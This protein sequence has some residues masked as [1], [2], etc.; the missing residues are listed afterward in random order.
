MNLSIRLRLTLL[1]F[2]FFALAG[3]L[4]GLASWL[5]LERSLTALMLH[6]LDERIDDLQSFLASRPPG[7]GLEAMRAELLREYRLKDEGKWLQITDGRGEWLYFS[8][9]G[10]VADLLS[11]LPPAPGSLTPFVPV[12]GHSLRSLTRELN[13]AGQTY[14]VSMAI[15]A[16]LSAVIL[17]R[18]GRDLWLLVPLVI[19]LA[20][21]VGHFL[22]RKALDPVQSIVTEVR[23]INERNLSTR[24]SVSRANDELSLLS[25]TLNQMLERIDSA[26]RSVRVLT[27]NAS[28]ELRT[29]LTLIR[30]RLEIALCFPRKIDYYQSVLEEVLAESV[31]MSALVENLLTMARY[32]AG[33]AQTELLPV[34][35][36]GLLSKAAREWIATAERLSLDLQFDGGQEPL[37]VLADPDLIE[38][39]VRIL[40]DN[41]CRYTPPGG[42]VRLEGKVCDDRVVVTVQDSGIGIAEQDLPRIFERFYRAQQPRHHERR[43][44]GLGLA[45]ARWIAEQHKASI[46]VDSTPGSGSRFEFTFPQFRSD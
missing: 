4:L 20:A 10:R 7:T 44:S 22:S 16:D 34:D 14:H 46:T 12:R 25:Q 15:S 33:A 3:V 19:I 31:R 41:A 1:Y 39:M 28:H 6:E 40:V 27:A 43:G 38:R 32:D 9:R 26:F 24:L 2:S 29:P 35:L 11:P 21:V 23:R 13:V 37:W 36:S 17:A 8:S 18:F 30:T 5:L 45:L 42:W